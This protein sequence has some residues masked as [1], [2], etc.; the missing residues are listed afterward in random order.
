M[1]YGN[2][3]YKGAYFHAMDR[4]YQPLSDD[5]NVMA[6]IEP[7]DGEPQLSGLTPSQIGIPTP[8]MQNQLEALQ[9]KI[10][11]GASRVELGFTG[12]GKGSM[13]QGSTTPEMY[14][15]EERRDIK[16]LAEW[17]KV[18]LTT[19]ASIGVGNLSGLTEGG[20]NEMAREQAL[21]E[22]KR[23][24]DF[25]ADVTQGGAIVVH[26]GE[27]QRPLYD[28]YP[29]FMLNPA[30]A[31]LLEGERK[32][33]VFHIVDDRTGQIIPIRTDQPVPLPVWK[34]NESGKYLFDEKGEKIP[35]T[36][37]DPATGRERY[38]MEL[39]EW[40][41]FVRET[42]KWNSENPDKTKRTPELQYQI[43]QVDLQRL[44]YAGMSSFYGGI[45]RAKQQKETLDRV[46]KAL[47]FYQNLEKNLPV[48]E[49]WKIMFHHEPQ[50]RGILPASP[51]QLPSE[52]LT[53]HKKQIEADLQRMIFAEVAYTQQ[54][55]QIKYTQQHLMPIRDYAIKKTADT[56]ARAGLFAMQK[57]EQMRTKEPLFIAPENIF[58]ETYGS[59]PHELRDMVLESR[60]SMASYLKVKGYDDQHAKELAEQHI[61]A[62]FDVGHG[63]TWRKYFIGDADKS[64]AEND[65][66]FKKWLLDEVE[67][68]AKDKI[69]GHVHI[70]DNFGYEDE[71]VDPGMGR[72]PIKEFIERVRKH[73]AITSV[74][75]E[76]AHQDYRAMLS[77]WRHFGSSIYGLARPYGDTWADVWRGYFG[78]TAPPYFLYGEAA[79]DP[80]HWV[81]WSGTRLE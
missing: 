7:M 13:G 62:T 48:E 71:H 12:R 36:E 11:Q 26:T 27:F 22:I 45:E 1:L 47:Q 78:R 6:P 23:A 57:S 75:V 67:K 77:G 29:E 31:H 18:I 52:V 50:L 34:T 30:E 51:S 68:L 69:L 56:I 49:Q 41:Y 42:E 53:E 4:G 3:Y 59:H 65:K 58:P 80:E 28:N 60:K 64:I 55:E 44:Q 70:S 8:P 74:T 73:G 79:P 39:R 20:F 5:A 10:R 16:E 61:K 2:N 19:H 9:A 76:P 21:N 81:V 38:K 14:G 72:A 24:V 25:A 40:D 15:M 46:K 37:V 66:A 43:E 54:A 32:K 35:E 33:A 63:Y 17:N